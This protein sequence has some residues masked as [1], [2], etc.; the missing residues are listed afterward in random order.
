MRQG[1]LVE[2]AE[3]L[4]SSQI[5]ALHRASLEILWDP[6]ILVFNEEAAAIFDEHGARVE[7]VS[8]IT[9]HWLVRLPER[10]VTEALEKAPPVVKLGARDPANTLL[11]NGKEP[12]IYFGSGSESNIFV[13]VRPQE[14]LPKGD[15]GQPALTFPL[16]TS[17]RGLLAD[18]CRAARLAEH[19]EHLDFFI[20]PVNVQDPEIDEENKDVNKFFACLDNTTKHVMSGLT[21]LNQLPAVIRMAELVAGGREALRENPLI[22]FITCLTK[23]PLQ[24][25]AD[26]TQKLIA[27]VREG[28]PVV[29][30][31][32]PQGG[33]TAPIDEAGM[34]AQINAEILSAVTLSQLVKEGAP[35]IYGSVPVRARM[36]NLHDM[37]GAPEFGHY[38]VSCAQ[39]ARFYGLPCYSTAGVADTKFPGIQATVE[40][41]YS[42]LYVAQGGPHL[43]HYAFGLLEETNAFCLEQ[44][45]M[46]NAHIGLAK[47]F[48]RAPEVN[49]E[50]LA[51]NLAVI[52]KVMAS[53]QKLYAR[54]A[55]KKMHR[56]EIYPGYP[57]EEKEETG[58]W[59]YDRTLLRVK[60]ETE[61]LLALPPRKLLPEVREKVFAETPGLLPQLKSKE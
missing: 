18:L 53:P 60:A 1:I 24:L 5:E 47:F 50:V 29:I 19:L 23:S 52:R 37:Y 12:C 6:G 38:Q 13:E 55:R 54:Y 20:R 2:P 11:L 44:A 27:I 31:S 17:R 33:S 58:G 26:T 36:D 43:I 25:V 16:F 7:P 3:R 46:D 22:S 21:S 59:N 28:L 14:F 4:N 32:S 39:L 56:G 9:E 10:I 34:V 51:E 45:V 40:K 15:L 42:Y 49:E 35:V 30:S 48:L 61:R 8:G 41:L 57:F